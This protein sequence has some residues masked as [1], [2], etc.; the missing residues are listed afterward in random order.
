[1]SEAEKEMTT[2]KKPEKK[3]FIVDRWIA[4][5]RNPVL[6]ELAEWAEMLAF[7]AVIAL[8]INNTII[9]NSVVPTG[10]M[11]T[12]INTG[13]RVVGLRLRYTFGEPGRGDV[14][15]FKMAWKCR[16][17]KAQGELPAPEVCPSCGESLSHY[18]TV[19]YVKRVIG[20]PGDKIEIKAE[21]SCKQSEIVSDAA[22]MF[23]DGDTD[24][25]VV[26]AAVYVNGQKLD[27]PYLREPMLYTGDLSYEVPEDCY[28]MLGDNRNC[29]RDARYW[30]NSY[31]DRDRMVAKVYFRY[32]KKPSII[33]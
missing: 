9:A 27:E 29:S 14:A 7:A 17:C 15:I 21:G 11:E 4:R 32:W 30:D 24:R 28:F 19:H 25:E 16:H 23:P 3:Q 20:V 33:R 22:A 31:I 6:R 5:I 1:M 18:E 10:S 8:F 13:D 12:T 2:E 26:T